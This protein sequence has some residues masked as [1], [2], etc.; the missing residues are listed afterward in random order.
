MLYKDMLLKLNFHKTKILQE[1]IKQGYFP[2]KEEVE[3]VLKGI[4][5]RL[6]LFEA[7]VCIPGQT[8]NAKEINHCLEMLYYDIAFLY[9][10][11]EQIYVEKF[12]TMLLNVETHM[13]YLESLAEHFK[14]RANEEIK[15][16]SLGK[17]L[18][19]K[20]DNWDIDVN[21]ESLDIFVGTVDLIQGSEISCF[22]N[23][24]N[25]SKENI[26]FKFRAEDTSK[27]FNALPYNYNNDTY[28]VPGEIAVKEHDLKLSEDF[29]INSEIIIPFNPTIGNDYKILGGKDKIVVTDKATNRVTVHDFPTVEKPFEALDN[30]YISFYVENKGE[31]E[32][33]FNMR[34]YHS[35]FSIQDGIIKCD[36]DIQRI[37]LDV[38]KGFI[39]Y[40]HLDNNIKTWATKEDAIVDNNALIYDG[41]LLVRDFK[42]KE[43]VK[44][45]TTKY[46]VTVSITEM[47]NDEVIES[48][49]IKEVD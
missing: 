5:D 37:F 27:N 42:I 4:D 43:Y 11:L 34:P 10:V 12:N 41:M 46:N 14:K 13:V 28:L 3:E 26:L 48:I 38:P 7:Y 18:L 36:K 47:D 19:F 20:T 35:N 33:N 24:N 23:I 16:T 45:K 8:F 9:K 31:L 15:G 44:D 17:T 21:D 25:T 2:N 22:A 32:Y 40:F 29:N 6:A 30:C 1:F 49:Y 39:C